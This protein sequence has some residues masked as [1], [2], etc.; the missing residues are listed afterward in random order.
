L[1]LRP[2]PCKIFKVSV[3]TRLVLFSQ[4]AL[5]GHVLFI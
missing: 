1:H 3:L 5:I 2:K 4:R